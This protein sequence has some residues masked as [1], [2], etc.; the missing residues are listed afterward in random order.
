M[1]TAP[2][3]R[4]ALVAATASDVPDSD[5][6]TT[7]TADAVAAQIRLHIDGTPVEVSPKLRRRFETVG[8]GADRA[9]LATYNWGDPDDSAGYKVTLTLAC[10]QPF[11]DPDL[12][13]DDLLQAD[14]QVTRTSRGGNLSRQA[15]FAGP[16]LPGGSFQVK[17][18]R[19]TISL[20]QQSPFAGFNLSTIFEASGLP[21][22]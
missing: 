7:P 15:S 9:F 12:T 14:L 13:A 16:S 18:D 20:E 11:D 8:S 22:S 10:A 1:A 2:H 6:G 4:Y 21:R 3:E 17:G 19:L 5:A